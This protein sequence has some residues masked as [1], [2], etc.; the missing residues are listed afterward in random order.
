[1]GGW[2]LHAYVGGWVGG[3]EGGW[4]GGLPVEEGLAAEHGR[5]LFGNALPDVLDGGGV[6]DKGG[7]HLGWVGGW[8][9][10]WLG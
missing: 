4:V 3:R 9:G 5:E 6:A 2:D 7:R 1:M 8:V 10:G